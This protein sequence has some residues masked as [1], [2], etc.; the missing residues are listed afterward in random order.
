[1]PVVFLESDANDERGGNAMGFNWEL[2]KAAHDGKG[3]RS[4][5]VKNNGNETITPPF[6]G[7]LMAT[8][9]NPIKASEA[10][11]SRFVHLHWGKLDHRANSGEHSD[12]LRY[13]DKSETSGFLPMILQHEKQMIK[14]SLE[15][16]TEFATVLKSIGVTNPRIIKNHALIMGLLV[17]IGKVLP[18]DNNMI[19]NAIERL[20][21]M[22]KERQLS[23]LQDHPS[24][25]E[26]WDAYDYLNIQQDGMLTQTVLNHSCNPGV[27]AINLVHFEKICKERGINPPEKRELKR[28]IQGNKRHKYIGHKSIRSN[29]T[30]KTI[31]CYLFE[32]PKEQKD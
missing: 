13:Q 23:T 22:A 6:R 5:G 28:H 10:T 32:A 3:I 27:I 31:S 7:T 16:Q 9:N 26:F 18:L 21:V 14:T 19:D 29:I 8:H 30:N 25:E 17:A 2:L 24:V 20:T 4:R 12:I 11:M 15:Q 1:M